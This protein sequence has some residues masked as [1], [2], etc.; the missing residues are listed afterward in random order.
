[1]LH[2]GTKTI[3][4]ER[5]ILRQAKTEDAQPMFYN[6]C[7]DDEVTKYLTWPTHDSVNVTKWVLDSWIAGYEKDDFYQWM[8]VLKEI[9]QPIGTIDVHDL[10]DAVNRGEIG[11]CIGKKWWRKG[12]MSEALT[13]VLAF[14]FDEVGMNELIANHDTRNPNSGAVMKKCGMKFAGII[15]H[16]GKNNQGF[17]D[18]CRHT[19]S[20]EV[21]TQEWHKFE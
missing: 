3:E 5:L 1:M 19:L 17:C 10:D 16:G 15:P 9:D 21:W 7:S 14:M 2:K 11:Y 18:I 4:T 6:W 8:I 13:A 20:A 12:I